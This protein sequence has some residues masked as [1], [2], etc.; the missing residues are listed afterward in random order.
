MVFGI[1]PECPSAFFGTGV[2]LR[3]NPQVERLLFRWRGADRQQRQ[4]TG[5]ETRSV[6][7][8]K[9]VVRGYLDYFSIPSQIRST[10]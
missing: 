7:S 8:K 1:I 10:L 6:K 3:Q 5:D 4:R 2:Q 9:L